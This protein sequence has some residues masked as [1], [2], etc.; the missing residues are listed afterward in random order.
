MG[1]LQSITYGFQANKQTN[2]KQNKTKKCLRKK[3]EENVCK[4][5]FS[6]GLFFLWINFCE[7]KINSQKFI[8]LL[9]LKINKT[10]SWKDRSSQKLNHLMQDKGGPG[11]K[12]NQDSN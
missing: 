2:K 6:N 8:K 1:K 9:F 12:F 5:Q 3:E 10:N 11:S 7:L 4:D